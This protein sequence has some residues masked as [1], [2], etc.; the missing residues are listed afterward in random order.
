VA[1]CPGIID[2]APPDRSPTPTPTP[3]PQGQ[4]VSVAKARTG[5]RRRRSGWITAAAVILVVYGALGIVYAPLLAG[6]AVWRFL[7]VG[8]STYTIVGVLDIGAG[9]GL[10]RLY[11]WARGA[12]ILLTAYGLLFVDAPALPAAAGTGSWFAI[13][14]PG[15]VGAV[16]VLFAVLRRWPSEPAGA[17]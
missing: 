4:A 6:G 5:Q 1:G 16:V 17:G 9:I 11:G 14:W 10:L 15:L 13:D 3:A 12:A 7:G 8:I 2:T